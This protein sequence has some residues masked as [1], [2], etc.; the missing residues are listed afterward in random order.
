MAH[1]NL[2]L[3]AAEISRLI[4]HQGAMCLLAGVIHYDTQSIHCYATSHQTLDN[5]LRERGQLYASCGIEYA[6]QAMAIHGALTSQAQHPRAGRLAGVR[7]VEIYAARLD[8][9][10][11]TLDIRAARLMGDE[12][13]M[14]YEF[15]LHANTRLL[16]QGKATVML[17]T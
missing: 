2:V 9:L 14:M 10:Q 17:I 16:L 15:S 11:D 12:N 13:S 7:A 8:D 3:T 6:A 5:P 4:P 1:A